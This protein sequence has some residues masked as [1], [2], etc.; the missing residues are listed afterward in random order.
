MKIKPTPEEPGIL[1][2]P[3]GFVAFITGRYLEGEGFALEEDEVYSNMLD[4][5]SWMLIGEGK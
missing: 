4:T 3:V 1:P 5:R 2:S